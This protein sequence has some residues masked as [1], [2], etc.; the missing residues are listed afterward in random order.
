MDRYV[1]A[2]D[3][4]KIA[5]YLEGNE[6]DR[7]GKLTYSELLDTMANYVK[8]AG[9]EKGNVVVIYLPMLMVLPIAMLACARIGV[10]HSV[11][12]AG[13]SVDAIAQRIT[14]CKLKV[15]IQDAPR[16][17]TRAGPATTSGGG[18]SGHRENDVTTV[19]ELPR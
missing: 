15:E 3:G 18:G 8:S 7:D 1:E 4:A 9:F 5:M 16:R 2:R 17:S 19:G 12:F 10:V 11:V 13:F 6:H 14:D